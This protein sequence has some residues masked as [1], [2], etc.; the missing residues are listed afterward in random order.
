MASK[1]RSLE[2]NA[3]RKKTQELMQL[4]NISSM[5]DIQN[6]FKEIIVEFKENGLKAL[7]ADL[8]SVYAAVN[9]HA[10]LNTLDT[11]RERERWDNKYPKISQSWRSSWINLSTCFKY[12]RRY[13]G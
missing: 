11:F 3:R 7:M 9:E 13:A 1:N 8:K 6:L 4:A 10:A 5:D 12:P 2:E